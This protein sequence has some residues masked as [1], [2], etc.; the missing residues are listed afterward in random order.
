MRCGDGNQLLDP[1]PLLMSPF[2]STGG[3]EVGATWATRAL[4][5]DSCSIA[6]TSPA[7]EQSPSK[8][9]ILGVENF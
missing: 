8:N 4:P 2:L 9:C 5:R 1:E 3:E 6:E 7:W